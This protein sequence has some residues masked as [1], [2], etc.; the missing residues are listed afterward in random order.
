MV[1]IAASIIVDVCWVAFMD[2][3]LFSKWGMESEVRKEGPQ[4]GV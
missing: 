4:G 2:G 3:Y 1:A